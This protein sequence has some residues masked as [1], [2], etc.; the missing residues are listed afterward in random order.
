MVYIETW[1]GHLIYVF[2]IFGLLIFKNVVFVVGIINAISS[3][4]DN[5][6][7]F[8]DSVGVIVFIGE[9]VQ[10]RLVYYGSI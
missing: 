6:A 10:S 5:G 8:A 1:G 3:F 9:D 7:V 4:S 2:E